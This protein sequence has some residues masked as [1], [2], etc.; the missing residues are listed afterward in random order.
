MEIGRFGEF[1]LI[2]RISEGW[3]QGDVIVG[4]GD[5]AGVIKC[6]ERYILLTTDL[7]IE[8]V[9]FKLDYITPYQLGKKAVAVNLS[10]IAA[11]GGEPRY[12]LLSLALSPQTDLDF[13]D[14]F[15]MGMK[16]MAESFGVCLIGGDMSS[17]NKIMMNIT[18]IGFADAFVTRSGAEEGDAIF[19][20]GTIGDSSL[21]LKILEEK[22]MGWI[23]GEDEMVLR[24]IEVQ[25]RVREGSFIAK[26][27]FATSMIDISDG[28]LQDLSHILESSK[29]GATLWLE[30]IPLSKSFIRIREEMKDGLWDYVLSGGED[31]ELLFTVSS[32]K[33]KQFVMEFQR[34]FETSIT[35]IGV[36]EGEKGLRILD[37]KGEIIDL[38]PKGYNHFLIP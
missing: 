3:K 19:V 1:N 35:E 28:L 10:D 2:K 32:R 9:H 27:G 38:P 29:K 7:L 18:M 4:I 33:K 17:S 34:H 31:Y 15:N 26:K 20:T 30:R 11:M 36:I 6:G 24:H 16:H 14:E 5:D 37:K 13:I 12:F 8:D 22:G 23:K 25:P 21:G